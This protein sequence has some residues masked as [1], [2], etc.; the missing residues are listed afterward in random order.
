MISS[1]ACLP[2]VFDGATAM[3]FDPRGSV[4]SCV[5]VSAAGMSVAAAIAELHGAKI[6]IDPAVQGLTVR[7]TF[8][9]AS[10]GPQ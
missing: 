7:V 1:S 9:A 8:D 4:S 2:V 3:P 10:A 5:N 6:A